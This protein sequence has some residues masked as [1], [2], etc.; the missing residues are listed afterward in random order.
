LCTSVQRFDVIYVTWL[1]LLR[2]PRIKYFENQLQFRLLLLKSPCVEFKACWTK[3]A[4]TINKATTHFKTNGIK[5]ETDIV[6]TLTILY[7]LIVI[8]HWGNR[9]ESHTVCYLYFFLLLYACFFTYV[10]EITN[11]VWWV[12]VCV[13]MVL[14]GLLVQF[15]K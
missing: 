15:L 3:N 10:I 13:H 11:R 9:I 2:D 4:Y 14:A 6:F 12:V 7:R 1:V 8:Y 5:N